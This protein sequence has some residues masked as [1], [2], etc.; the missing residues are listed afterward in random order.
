[1]GD[2]VRPGKNKPYSYLLNQTDRWLITCLPF[3]FSEIKGQ[4]LHFSRIR[5]STQ[6]KFTC[7]FSQSEKVSFSLEEHEKTRPLVKMCGI[8][9]A[10]DAAMATEAGADFIGM[11]IWPN[12]KHSVSLSEVKEI[13]KVA[14]EYGAE[15]VGVFVDDD[16]D[17]IL[18]ASDASNLELLQLHGNGSRE[19]FPVIL[20]EKR[21]IYVLHANE[22][23]NLLPNF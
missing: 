14:R 16:A 6:N 3:V 5:S 7:K 8:T 13:S 23:G 4:I 20:Q 19:A 12:S 10:K 15:P 1:M 9:S 2:Q 21:L 18:R 11:I 17:T 22:D